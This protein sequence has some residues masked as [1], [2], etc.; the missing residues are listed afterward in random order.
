MEFLPKEVRD[1]LSA[2]RTTQAR[3]K[4]RMRVRVGGEEFV[5]LRYWD[6][7]FSIDASHAPQVRG[8]VDVFDGARHLSQCLV[9]ASEGD[10]G[11]AVFDIK[12]RTHA[13]DGPAI[14]YVR[15][16]GAP[17]ALIEKA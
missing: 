12:R 7:G 10:A 4:G 17:T 2:A 11:E 13:A 5:I 3:T 1:G 8:F 14:D 9:V 16:D 6:N 15:D